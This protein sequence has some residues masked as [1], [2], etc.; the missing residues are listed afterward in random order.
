MFD[1]N[2]KSMEDNLFR[3]V[4]HIKLIMLED[5]EQNTIDDFKRLIGDLYNQQK[6]SF[7]ISDFSYSYEVK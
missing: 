1:K 2:F 7:D 6:T 5:F 3:F 4:K